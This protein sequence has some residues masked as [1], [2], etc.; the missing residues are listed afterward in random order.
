MGAVSTLNNTWCIFFNVETSINNINSKDPNLGAIPRYYEE[1]SIR[2]I[3][4]IRSFNKSVNIYTILFKPIEDYNSKTISFLK[5][6][7]IICIPKLDDIYTKQIENFYSGFWFIPLTGLLMENSRNLNNQ[8]NRLFDL[9]GSKIIPEPYG[10]KLD[11]DMVMLRNPFNCNTMSHFEMMIMHEAILDIKSHPVVGYYDKDFGDDC[12]ER[13]LLRPDIPNQSNTCLI[14]SNLNDTIYKDWYHFLIEE[15]EE[16]K[17]NNDLFEEISFDILY[18]YKD[19]TIPLKNFQIGE[20][21]LDYTTLTEDEKEHILF[22]HQR[23]DPNEDQI[24]LHF[25][26][27][28]IKKEL[29]LIMF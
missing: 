3:K 25:K 12:Q 6:N 16:N 24:K 4:S 13:L 14:F 28:K 18:P 26:L 1:E 11:S 29:A 8:I 5:E 27:E 17:I 21:Y 23:L 22:Y 19:K 20:N 9:N 2:L 15:D 7:A 10:L